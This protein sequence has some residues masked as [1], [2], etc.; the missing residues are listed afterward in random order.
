MHCGF[1]VKVENLRKHNNANKLQIATFFGSDTIVDMSVKVGDIGVYFPVDL[2]LSDEYCTHNNL[3]RRKDENGNNTGGFL[4]PEKRNIKAIKLRGEK[5][6]GLYMPL[7]S[8]AYCWDL[9]LEDIPEECEITVP[10]GVG[11]RVTVLNG[12]DICKKYIPK[13]YRK[14][15]E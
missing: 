9:D 15:E 6:D 5:S 12:H 10:L 2:Q 7:K 14:D 1:V 3:V 4:D 13:K 11:D 8:F